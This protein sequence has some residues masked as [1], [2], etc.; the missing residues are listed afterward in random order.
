MDAVAKRK[1]HF[2]AHAG[3]Q[4]PVIQSVAWPLQWHSDQEVRLIFIIILVVYIQKKWCM[5][6]GSVK[7]LPGFMQPESLILRS[8]MAASHWAPPSAS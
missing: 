4:I 5:K 1:H 6:V 7:K 8:K 2:P 3:I